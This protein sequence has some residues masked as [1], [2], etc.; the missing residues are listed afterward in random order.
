M[1]ASSTRNNRSGSISLGLGPGK[2]RVLSP[3]FR[4]EKDPGPCFHFPDL[5]CS[6]EQSWDESATL[7][8]P[9][10][11]RQQTPPL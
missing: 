4:A 3:L 9:E 10:Y 5:N 2:L 7:A 6:G 1:S 11:I 8:G